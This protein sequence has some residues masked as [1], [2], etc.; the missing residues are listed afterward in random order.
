MD[1]IVELPRTTKHHEAIWVVMNRLTKSSDFLA[2]K[3]TFTTEQLTDLYISEVVRL[4]G[5]TLS[6]VSDRDTKFVSK[7]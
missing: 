6:I 1:F 4:H 7:F 2:I 3:V 5:I